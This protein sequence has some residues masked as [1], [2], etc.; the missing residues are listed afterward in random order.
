M[1]LLLPAVLSLAALA[2]CQATNDPQTNAALTGAVAGSVLGAAV[3]SSNDRATGA[4]VGAIVGS[5]AGALIGRTNDGQCRYRDA[6]GNE[7]TAACR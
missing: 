6:N 5:A 1:R 7:F 3:S 2:G 4:V